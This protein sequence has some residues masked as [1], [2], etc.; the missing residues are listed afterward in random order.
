MLPLLLSY[1]IFNQTPI[2][3]KNWILGD[4]PPTFLEPIDI[5]CSKNDPNCENGKNPYDHWIQLYSFF[6]WT[7]YLEHNFTSNKQGKAIIIFGNVYCLRDRNY[8][9]RAWMDILI[10]EKLVGWIPCYN[11]SY[12]WKNLK[13]KFFLE[14][15]SEPSHVLRLEYSVI[16]P[17]VG[18]LSI[19]TMDTI[20]IGLQV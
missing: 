2:T 5:F 10:D 12:D 3:S 11:Q 13:Y 16:S 14:K 20:V 7:Y 4:L 6:E 15:L 1:I 9:Q 8:P 19:L 17:A 18:S